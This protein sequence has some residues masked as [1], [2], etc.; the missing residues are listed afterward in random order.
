M[1]LNMHVQCKACELVPGDVI[2]TGEHYG[3]ALWFVI[4]SKTAVEH[5]EVG[6]ELSVHD[7]LMLRCYDPVIAR[8][9]RWHP[10]WKINIHISGRSL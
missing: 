3:I 7:I 6:D 2:S 4:S 10:L 5:D 9:K 8:V 1:T